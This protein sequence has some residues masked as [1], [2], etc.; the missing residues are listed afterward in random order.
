[1]ETRNGEEQASRPEFT[2]AGLLAFWPALL[3]SLVKSCYSATAGR[4]FSSASVSHSEMKP[5]YLARTSGGML[6]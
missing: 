5:R 6:R 3:A 4:D 1:M 2:P